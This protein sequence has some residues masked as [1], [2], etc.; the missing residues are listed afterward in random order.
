MRR[1]IL[2]SHL[3]VALAA[4]VF[5]AL[6]GITGSIMA[7]EG[8]LGHLLHA[9]VSYVAPQGQPLPISR[10]G[11]AAQR[12]Y[13]DD[14]AFAYLIAQSPDISYAVALRE[15]LVHVNQYTGEVVGAE[16]PAM[17]F[18]GYVH[19][20]HLRLAMMDKGR[21]IGGQVMSW[22]G[23]AALYLLLSGA[24]LWWPAKR[25][26]I[27]RNGGSRRFWFDLHN[28]VGIFSLLFLLLL[29][30]TG[31][32]IGFERETTPLLYKMTGS[33][34]AARPKLQATPIPGKDQLGPDE[35]LAIGLAA[36]PG[37]QAIA[38]NLPQGPRGVYL[39]SAHYPED[40][41]PGG[42]TRIGID[43]YSG[44]VLYLL[45]SRTA[46][47]GYRAV[48]WN[49]AIHTGD[50]FGMPSRIVMSLAS[51]MMPFQL[52]TGL[53]LWLKR[54]KAEKRA[55]QAAAVGDRH[56]ASGALS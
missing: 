20:L 37:A 34:P 40:R 39:I 17:D 35:A 15:H 16:S 27:Q 42:R 50:I 11:A 4:G 56:Q 23:V 47:G 52:L 10:I 12:A 28:V 53:V 14:R 2:T 29:T 32:V 25:M 6:L 24:Y 5:I 45:D 48:N 13:P 38:L 9:K 51:A 18:L 19:Q 31:I 30:I 33:A 3:V 44:K 8:E 49:R 7:F 26:R 21:E 1:L 36:A 41:T 54:R 46:P 43:P 22:S 55:N